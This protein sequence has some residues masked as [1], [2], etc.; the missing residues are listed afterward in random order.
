MAAVEPDRAID[1][2]AGAER[3]KRKMANSSYQQS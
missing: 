3:S 2:I 1:E